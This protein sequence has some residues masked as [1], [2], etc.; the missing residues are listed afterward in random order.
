MDRIKRYH[1]LVKKIPIQQY[2]NY[3]KKDTK[4]SFVAFLLTK[5]NPK[6][7]NLVSKVTIWQHW[8]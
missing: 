4:S 3:P 6:V 2:I 5:K 7:T 1:V 8:R